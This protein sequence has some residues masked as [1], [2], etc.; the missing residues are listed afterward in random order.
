MWQALKQLPC[1]GCWFWSWYRYIPWGVGP[2]QSS[3][4]V[5]LSLCKRLMLHSTYTM[6]GVRWNGGT[7]DA[8]L[9][10][11]APMK[12]G[13]DGAEGG[14]GYSV[15]RTWPAHLMH[16]MHTAIYA[17][18]RALTWHYIFTMTLR[19]TDQNLNKR[20]EGMTGEA[21]YTSSLPSHMQAAGHSTL[22]RWLNPSHEV[23]RI[24]ADMFKA[25]IWGSLISTCLVCDLFVLLANQN[26]LVHWWP[27]ESCK[28]VE[29][30]KAAS[31]SVIV[32]NASKSFQNNSQC[33]CH[34]RVSAWSI[35]EAALP[36]WCE[37]PFG[38]SNLSTSPA[39]QWWRGEPRS[40]AIHRRL[41]QMFP[42]CPNIS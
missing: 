7:G 17:W 22:M 42:T 9:L 32:V 4:W 35:P 20:K 10:P 41:A 37:S 21:K 15:M 38:D 16:N 19:T 2:I 11:R 29:L 30:P 18:T 14:W 40:V 25:S 23:L 24:H 12:W 5:I 28:I 31:K 39:T 3:P 36:G 27:P 26:T 33:G 34:A 8:H 6:L 1:R 13:W